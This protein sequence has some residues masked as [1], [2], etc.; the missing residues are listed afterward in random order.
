LAARQLAFTP[1]RRAAYI[2]QLVAD[3]VCDDIGVQGVLLT[4]RDY[5][6]GGQDLR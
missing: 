1:R 6:I 3:P 5:G 2:R 4:L